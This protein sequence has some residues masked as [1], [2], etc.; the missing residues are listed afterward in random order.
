MFALRKML[1]FSL[2]DDQC[3]AKRW[4]IEYY[5]TTQRSFCDMP[6]ATSID[7]SFL[8][9]PKRRKLTQH[10]KFR[11]ANM[12]TTELAAVISESSHIHF[13][14]WLELLKDLIDSWKSGTEVALADLDTGR[15]C[16]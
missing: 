14:R 11:K 9:V 1:G 12:L 7:V 10:E 4:T 13:Y 5:R 16:S 8:E 6:S 3:C 2:F 15:K